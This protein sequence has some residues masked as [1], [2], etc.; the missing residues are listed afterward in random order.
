MPVISLA[1]QTS[2]VAILLV[3]GLGKLTPAGLAAAAAMFGQLG[4]RQATRG[5][6]GALAAAELL[7]AALIAVP[8]TAV[9]GTAAAV[10]LF[11]A[12]TAGVAVV[13]GR[14]LDVRC[15]CFGRATRLRPVHLV[16]NGVLLAA[17]AGTC[18]ATVARDG[19]PRAADLISLAVLLGV[20]TALVLIRLDDLVA[21]F[22]LSRSRF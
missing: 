14:K 13:L 1:G 3:S 11:G 17:A 16:R 20:V 6:A 18:L 8:P 9:V 21:A 22:S 19:P 10:G 5:L 4:V 15:A 2:L 12:L 7:V